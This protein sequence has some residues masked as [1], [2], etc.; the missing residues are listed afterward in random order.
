[1]DPRDVSRSVQQVVC[2]HCRRR[3]RHCRRRR[4]L[5]PL[6]STKRRGRALNGFLRRNRD[7]AL[8]CLI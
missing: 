3:R 6:T 8:F 7:S 1:M 2:R 4:C 5:S